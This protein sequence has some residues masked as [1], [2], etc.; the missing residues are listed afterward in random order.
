MKPAKFRKRHC[1]KASFA[2][3]K[4]S[5]KLPRFNGNFIEI[6]G[7]EKWDF[8]PPVKDDALYAELN[9]VLGDR[10]REA[11][12]NPDKVVRLEGTDELKASV[13][14]HFA[15]LEDGERYTPKAIGEAFEAV[16]KAEV[17]GGILSQGIRPDGRRPE[18]IRPIWSQV[19][20]LPRT[21]GSA[22]FTRGQT[23]A[24]TISHARL[25]C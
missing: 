10:L 11:V 5:E 9:N 3:T 14:A 23:Q 20:Y 18:E 24:L 19:G 7:K 13:L 6:A 25:D 17:R 8:S 4:K 2:L 22:I 21:H 1:S 12:H 15:S 16:L